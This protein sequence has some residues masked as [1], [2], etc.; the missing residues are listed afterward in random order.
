MAFRPSGEIGS[1]DS[2]FGIPFFPSF[3]LHWPLGIDSVGL[4][5]DGVQTMMW[6]DAIIQHFSDLMQKYWTPLQVGWAGQSEDEATRFFETFTAARVMFYG[7]AENEKRP[8]DVPE[9]SVGMLVQICKI[10][11]TAG[12]VYGSA[13]E[14]AYQTFKQ[15]ANAIGYSVFEHDIEP[16]ATT[17]GMPY[18]DA[19]TGYVYGYIEK[20]DDGNPIRNPDGTWKVM[21]KPGPPTYPE[22]DRFDQEDRW[23]ID[24]LYEKDSAMA[25]PIRM[26]R[27]DGD[28]YAGL[29]DVDVGEPGAG[30]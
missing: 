25:D 4:W 20:D 24:L 6:A 18:M 17:H 11:K 5:D 15:L 30:R 13:E 29:P 14:T 22:Y 8:D 16:S 2:V 3:G 28:P 23:W 26:N 21:D 1:Y 12:S 7:L 10:V 19:G 9:D 27:A